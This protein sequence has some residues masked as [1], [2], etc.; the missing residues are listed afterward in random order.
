MWHFSSQRMDEVIQNDVPLLIA[1][2]QKESRSLQQLL[3]DLALAKRLPVSLEVL[4]VL[5]GLSSYQLLEAIKRLGGIIGDIS[6]LP[7]LV[8]FPSKLFVFEPQ[9]PMTP[10]V[11]RDT[12]L[13]VF[14]TY[15]EMNR[16]SSAVPD[17]TGCNSVTREKCADV[18]CERLHFVQKLVQGVTEEDS[19]L[20]SYM[21][22]CRNAA[23]K[24]VHVSPE[25]DVV[26]SSAP[27]GGSRINCDIRTFPLSIFRDT[28]I[29]AILMDPPWDIHMEL[30]Y[31][32]LTDDEMR[33]LPMHHVHDDGFVFIWA[34]ARTI[35]TARDCLRLWGYT[36]VDEIVW[37]KTNQVGGIVRSGRTGHWLNH[38][39]EHC[40]IGMKGDVSWAN[41]GRY[42][43]D[44]DVIVAPVREN[45]R[46]PDELYALIDRLVGPGA[47]CLEL[48][49]RP[50]NC[51]PGWIT[52]GN[53][54]GE[55]CLAPEVAGALPVLVSIAQSMPC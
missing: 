28:Q 22:L 50:H 47:L 48:F 3:T 51:R 40:L 32:T 31:G 45:S 14:G 13:S 42:R 11:V 4:S 52:L 25:R 30:S 44:C 16:C 15:E 20:C 12:V 9:P 33:A 7:F 38:S 34:T 43:K 37:V 41:V 36:R 53:Q 19:G 27:G 18:N 54:L 17:S 39:K 55:N 24:F 2:V 8:D 5:S 29:R 26:V 10:E 35:E 1:L 6:E 49:G 23:C 21:D 46:K